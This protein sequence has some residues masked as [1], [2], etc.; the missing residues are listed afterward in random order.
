MMKVDNLVLGAGISGLACANEYMRRGKEVKVFEAEDHIGGLC[1]SFMVDGFRFDSAVHLSFTQKEKARHFFDTTEYQVH[2]PISYN[3]YNSLWLKHPLLNNMYPMSAE[4]K[5][6][7]IESFIAR[8]ENSN[9]RDYGQWLKA[10]YGNVIAERFYYIY[11]RKYWAMEPEQLS[12]SWV[13]S[14]LN[15]PDIHKVLMGAFTDQTGNDYYAK[16]MRYPKGNG[17][18]ETFLSPLKNVEISCNKKAVWIDLNEKCVRFEDGTECQYNH[19]VSSLPLPKLVEC[20][21]NVPQNIA[22]SASRLVATKVSL[23][24]IGF[25]KP[26]IAR[27]LWFYIYDTDIMAARVNSPSKKSADNAP[28]G[29]SS[30]QFEIYHYPDEEINPEAI[31]ENV[32]Y[33]LK[34]MG[35]CE[36]QDIIFMD[37]RLLPYG[38]VIFTLDMEKDR[39]LVKGYLEDFDVKT[40][41]RFGEWDYLWSDQSYL[42]GLYAGQE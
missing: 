27:W 31:V 34:K 26:D 37:Y 16:E 21:H 12:T 8:K 32:R 11:T 14:R 41:G 3:Y 20:I 6:E 39:D 33:A 28:E 35:I 4:E 7:C 10:S 18:Y 24:S 17:G 5:T 38:N 22:N 40:I 15:T 36:E 9:I 2:S 25:N 29:C 13:G 30:L 23:V 19:L 1:H 42:S